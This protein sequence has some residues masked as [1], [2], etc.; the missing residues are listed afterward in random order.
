MITASGDFLGRIEDRT[1]VVGVIGLGYVGLIVTDH[2]AVDYAHLAQHARLVVDTRGVMRPHPG[3][4]RLVGLSGTSST[5][6]ASPGPL[7]L[8]E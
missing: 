5:R 1:A 8:V 3:P 6:D 2:S 7:A 4:A